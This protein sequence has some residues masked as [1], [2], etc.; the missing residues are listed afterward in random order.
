MKIFDV[1]DFLDL[2]SAYQIDDVVYR[3]SLL[4]IV[5]RSEF[6]EDDYHKIVER[7]CGRSLSSKESSFLEAAGAAAGAG[8]HPLLAEFFQKVAESVKDGTVFGAPGWRTERQDISRFFDE[9]GRKAQYPKP[10]YKL[11]RSLARG[12][13]DSFGDD[14]IDILSCYYE[15][16]EDELELLVE[17]ADANNMETDRLIQWVEEYKDL[18]EALLQSIDFHDLGHFLTRHSGQLE[19]MVNELHDCALGVD[20]QQQHEVIETFLRHEYIFDEQ[21]EST[22]EWFYYLFIQAYKLRDKEAIIKYGRLMTS[23]SEYFSRLSEYWD[24]EHSEMAE[25]MDHLLQITGDGE[26]LADSVFAEDT[27][28][29]AVMERKLCHETLLRGAL[30]NQSMLNSDKLKRRRF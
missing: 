2:D 8:G 16:D 4:E 13:E 26:L 15:I 27:V 12:G 9:I 11:L 28:K 20:K 1:P 7:L 18:P 30:K 22:A 6:C 3:C 5:G 14:I 29:N 23:A 10:D 25:Y 24:S 21:S 17:L 19:S